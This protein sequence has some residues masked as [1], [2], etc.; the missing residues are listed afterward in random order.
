MIIREASSND[1]PLIVKTLKLSLGEQ[2]LPLSEAIWNF[3]H[4]D[5]PF[6]KSLVY[7]AEED[8]VI[9]GVRAFMRWEWKLGDKSYSAF[10][11]VDT[12]THPDHQ[13]KGIF[14]KL[15]L[16]AVETAV[17]R[18]DNFIFN[19]PNDQSRPG[20]LKMGWKAV[21]KLNVGLKPAFNSFWKF[22]H[23]IPSYDTK[24]DANFEDIE[25]LCE[26]WNE[27]LRAKNSLY[28]PKSASFLKWRYEENP[29]QKYEVIAT[30][31]IYLATYIKK[32]KGLKELRISECLFTE[33]SKSKLDHLI[34]SLSK[35][36][37][38]QIISYSPEILA[39]KWDVVNANIGPIL[40]LKDLNLNEREYMKFNKISNW[41][42]SLG[43]LEL[44]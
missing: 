17:E 29:L 39:L 44:F 33:G 1:I 13:G 41:S 15:T 26:I 5:N 3:K 38:A 18:G 20:Y 42:Y 12:A 40:T 34:A 24:L 31:D 16:K 10:R 9:V 6:G 32:R 14:K 8:G 30:N 23:Q 21:D 43:D 7:V 35:K 37:G 22:S 36:F 4:V 11:A 27:N 28:T 25:S 2:D 19:T